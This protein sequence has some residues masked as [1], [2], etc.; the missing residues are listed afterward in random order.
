MQN[1]YAPAFSPYIKAAFC[2]SLVVKILDVLLKMI[3]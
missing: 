2:I 3:L 1:L